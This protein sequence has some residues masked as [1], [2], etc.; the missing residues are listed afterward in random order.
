MWNC[1]EGLDKDRVKRKLKLIADELYQKDSNYFGP[2]L[3]GGNSGIA[4]FMYYYYQYTGDS[5]YLNKS[6]ELMLEDF[7]YINHSGKLGTFASGISGI[8]YTL[9]VLHEKLGIDFNKDEMF[10]PFDNYLYQKMKRCLLDNNYDYLHG[11]LGYCMKLVL[12]PAFTKPYLEELVSII[13]AKLNLGIQNGLLLP[14]QDSRNGQMVSNFGLSHGL[15]SI[16]SITT[17]LCKLHVKRKESKE[18]VK[19]LVDF[20]LS[21]VQNP[22]VVGSYFPL[23]LGV[24]TNK[25]K[26]R[27]AWCYGDMGVAMALLKAGMTLG[28]QELVKKSVSILTYSTTRTNVDVEIVRD[29]GLCHGSAG[30]AHI[31]LRAYN[32]TNNAEL[33]KAAEY[34][35]DVTLN[36]SKETN[37]SANYLAYKP[38]GTVKEFGFLEG[39]SG[40]GLV[41]IS[42]ISNI[43]P[44]WDSVLL[45]S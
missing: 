8:L 22:S 37:K 14:T 6:Q 2:G 20:I 35:V 16:I 9:D 3:M 41:L 36:F 45:I 43:E 40:I 31:F 34:W 29:A 28:D 44:D 25:H 1:L 33:R 18:I 39:I 7:E 26:S 4:L 24:D 23:Y 32:Y 12:E 17:D 42:A 30:L 19:I 10:R 5:K 13:Y 11:G 21:N 38:N 15:P 27:L